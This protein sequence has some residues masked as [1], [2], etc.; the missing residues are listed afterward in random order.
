M[1]VLAD[2]LSVLDVQASLYVRET[3]SAPFAVAV[4]ADSRR[5]R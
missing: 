1:D 5:I 3:F 2:V 4:P